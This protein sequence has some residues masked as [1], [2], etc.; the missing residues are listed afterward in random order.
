MTKGQVET[1][2][3]GAPEREFNNMKR[4]GYFAIELKQMGVPNGILKKMV[5]KGELNFGYVNWG[6][7]A[8]AFYSFSDIP[9][10]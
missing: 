7:G 6:K 1:I 4:A 8:H 2:L 5:R 3:M 10:A 9:L